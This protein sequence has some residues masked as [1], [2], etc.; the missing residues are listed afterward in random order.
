MGRPLLTDEMIE[1]ANRGERLDGRPLYDAEETKI[2]PTDT[3]ERFG[4][5]KPSQTETS[6][7]ILSQETMDIDVP[8]TVYKSRRIENEK[9]SVFGAKLNK[10][11]FIM[12]LLFI[13]LLIAMW[14]L[15]EKDENWYYRGYAARISAFG[16]SS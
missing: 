1:R 2:L 6:R 11:L 3:G 4:Y 13:A 16:G 8:H 14:K 5:A 9:R 10:I 12:I 7:S 15:Q